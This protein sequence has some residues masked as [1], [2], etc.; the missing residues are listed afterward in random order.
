[1]DGDFLGLGLKTDWLPPQK[2]DENPEL[3]GPGMQ[4]SFSNER[5]APFQLLSFKASSDDGLGKSAGDS[6]ASSR[7]MTTSRLDVETNRFGDKQAGSYYVTTAY[8]QRHLNAQ[9]ISRPQEA[10]TFPSPK[11]L[12]QVATNTPVLQ[13][14]VAASTEQNV[15]C[16]SVKPPSLG[17]FTFVPPAS[18]PLTSTSLVGFTDSRNATRSP[19]A[20]AQLTIFFGGSVYVYD[21]VSPEKAR[22]IMLLAGNGSSATGSKT[23]PLTQIQAPIAPITRPGPVD[24]FN[25]SGRSSMLSFSAVPSNVDQRRVKTLGA[26]DTPIRR[27][28]T[29]RAITSLAP[30]RP[31]IFPAVALPQARKASL[32]RFLEKRKERA[33]STSP[34][35]PGKRSPDRTDSASDSFSR[36]TNSTASCHH[37]DI[38]QKP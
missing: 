20:P 3:N 33:M 24:D 37:I 28:E 26:Y 16:S 10:R 1:M 27:P 12:S 34:Y 21:D 5:S 17:G 31:T 22:A 25:G 15:I 13:S 32:A 6:L 35:A 38:N 11:H 7:S 29:P 14:H 4:W 2:G 36:S 30:A 19:A 23:V 18:V 9:A 8:P